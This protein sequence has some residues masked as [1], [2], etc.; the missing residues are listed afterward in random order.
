MRPQIFLRISLAAIAIIF[1]TTPQSQPKP[2]NKPLIG[3]WKLTKYIPYSDGSNEWKAYGDS[4][5]YQKHLTDNHFVWYKYDEK[6]HKLLGMGGGSYEIKDGKYIEDIKFFYPPG[7]SELG[8][9]IPFDFDVP[10]NEWHHTGY[11][12]VMDIDE[13]TGKM[14]VVDSNKIEEKWVRTDKSPAKN[15]MVQ[16]AW[17]LISYRDKKDGNYI[18]YPEYAGYIKLITPTH[19]TWVYYNKNDDVIYAAGSGK[20]SYKD[21]KYSETIDMIY[22]E[23]NGQLGATIVFDADIQN[24]KWKHLGEIPLIVE[25]PG[26]NKSQQLSLIDEIWKARQ[27]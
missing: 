23:D 10:K 24:N 6:N 18:E 8:Q 3:S 16:G 9:A 17:D 26:G 25:D 22:P 19:F 21:G 11:A 7:S 12:K 20:Y 14:I 2:A 4:I 27:D 1:A 13:N 15:I 5:I